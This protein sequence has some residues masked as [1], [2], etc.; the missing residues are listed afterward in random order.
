MGDQLKVKR[1]TVLDGSA[2]AMCFDYAV[3]DTRNRLVYVGIAYN[4]RQRWAQHVRSSWWLGEVEVDRVEVTGWPTRTAA[5]FAE[6]CAINEQAAIYNTARE[7]SSYRRAREEEWPRPTE[8]VIYVPDR[9]SV[10]L[11]QSR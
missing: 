3:W 10:D 2:K 1:R 11:V 8:R 4:F 7:P 5:R 9:E 6:A